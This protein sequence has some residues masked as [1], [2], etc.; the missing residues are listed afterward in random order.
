M[1]VELL[2]RDRGTRHVD[3]LVAIEI[4]ELAGDRVGVVRMGQRGDQQ[5]RSLVD[6]ARLV[7]DL[8]LGG[9]RHL[10]VEVELVGAHA[11]PACVTE[12]MLWY[13]LGRSAG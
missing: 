13:Q 9:E 4:A 12:L 2:H 7:V 10:V 11:S 8:P 5:Q 6:A 1:R 3:L